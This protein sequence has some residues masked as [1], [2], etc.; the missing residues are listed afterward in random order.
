MQGI[1]LNIAADLDFFNEYFSLTG[2]IREIRVTNVIVKQED[3]D[4]G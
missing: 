3:I 4:S 2:N 1:K